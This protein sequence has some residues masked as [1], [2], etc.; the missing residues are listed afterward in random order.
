MTHSPINSRAAQTDHAAPTELAGLRYLPW[1]GQH[2]E[3]KER[4]WRG[5][6]GGKRMKKKGIVR[7][8]IKK[9]RKRDKEGKKHKR[10]RKKR[11]GVDSLL[12]AST[13]VHALV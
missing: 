1:E 5:K 7:E 2:P 8:E 4:L 6:E 9:L 13:M 12:C 10:K 3:R 11:R